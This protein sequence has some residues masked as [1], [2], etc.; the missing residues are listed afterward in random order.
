ML[1]IREEFFTMTVV[2]HR[3]R[4]P[5]EAL[6]APSLALLKARLDGAFGNL[7]YLEVSLPVA[8]ELELD[9]I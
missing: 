5:R 3:N 6:V 7:V 4:L 9:D 1:G 8:G 2:R